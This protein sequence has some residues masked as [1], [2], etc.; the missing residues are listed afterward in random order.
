M[1]CQLYN[2]NMFIRV[3]Q[4]TAHIKVY[5]Q[6][7]WVWMTVKLRQQDVKYIAKHCLNDPDTTER[8]QH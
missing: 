3:D 1:R 8:V 5:H 2:G 4:S 7:D 6:K